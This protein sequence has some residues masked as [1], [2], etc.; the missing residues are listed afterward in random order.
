MVAKRVLEV[1]GCLR[2]STA[3]RDR[4]AGARPADWRGARSPQRVIA[5]TRLEMDWRWADARPANRIDWECRLGALAAGG[6]ATMRRCVDAGQRERAQDSGGGQTHGETA[7]DGD[8][9]NH[10]ASGKRE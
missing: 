5:R 8:N 9:H 10:R 1:C 3:S 7:V 6:D 2:S 4:E